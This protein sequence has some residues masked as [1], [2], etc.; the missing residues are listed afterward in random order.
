MIDL[1]VEQYINNGSGLA[2]LPDGQVV[3]IKGG[4]P[5]DQVSLETESLEKRRG[6]FW[7]STHHVLQKSPFRAVPN[8]SHF[9]LCGGCSTLHIGAEH[10]LQLKA[11]AVKDSL[12]RLGKWSV[13]VLSLIDFQRF[14]SRFRGKFH[15][16]GHRLGWKSKRSRTVIAPKSCQ[17]LPESLQIQLGKI[18]ETV[19]SFSFRGEVFFAVDPKTEAITLRFQGFSK[20]WQALGNLRKQI[21]QIKGVAFAK[22]AGKPMR[23]WGEP[24][25]EL[26]WNPFKAVVYPEQ[27]FQSNPKS[28][29][30]FWKIVTHYMH[31][32]HPQKVW[33]VHAGSGFLTSRVLHGQVIASEPDASAFKQLN[34]NLKDHLVNAYCFKGT[35][36]EMLAQEGERLHELEG[37]IL[38]PPRMGLTQ[39]L[40]N[41]LI[42]NGPPSMLYFSC[43]TGTFARDLS[44]LSQAYDPVTPAYLL[45][46]NPG[47]LRTEIAAI[48]QRKKK[49]K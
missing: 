22:K 33:D 37:V 39:P 17:V 34:R 10:E 2:R 42:Q 19:A 23:T 32:F 36:E 30:V 3:F 5:G 45:N 16:D 35:A 49:I 13:P 9:H 15:A 40:K 46:V 26:D 7:S 41:W 11:K 21:P 6:V 38:D 1:E 48:F 27:F 47:T 4:L 44:Q 29:P 24:K 14:G 28:W 25:I 43:D 8:C 18:Q 20:R 12:K 31:Q